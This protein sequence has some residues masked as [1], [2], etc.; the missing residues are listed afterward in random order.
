MAVGEFEG[1]VP[2]NALYAITP[3]TGIELDGTSL[4]YTND[5]WNFAPGAF[6]FGTVGEPTS[7][8]YLKS[9][10]F[11]N[12]GATIRVTLKNIPAAAK[13]VFLECGA[14]PFFFFEGTVNPL[15][16]N[17]VIE[18]AAKD[19]WC[20][21][22]LPEHTGD[23][24]SLTFDVPILTGAYDTP[25]WGFKAECYS[26]TAD[27][28]DWGAKVS[29]KPQSDEIETNGTINRGDIFNVTLTFEAL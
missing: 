13:T 26:E 29:N 21:M 3:T 23:I 9:I 11:K 20:V 1:D 8:A 27:T 10:A 17:P 16:E 19:E 14:R 4:K 15:D 5:Q 2:E 22:V 18:A 7:S 25:P 24:A 6:L 28:W 12:M